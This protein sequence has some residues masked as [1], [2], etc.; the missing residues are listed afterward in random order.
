MISS[1][2]LGAAQI[3]AEIVL[4]T[5]V[6]QPMIV[7]VAADLM[8]GGKDAA[9]QIRTSLRHPTEDK[10]SG[11]NAEQIQKRIVFLSTRLG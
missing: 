1:M 4:S 5:A 9:D 2:S 10:K 6:N 3:L 7:A 8:T 11:A